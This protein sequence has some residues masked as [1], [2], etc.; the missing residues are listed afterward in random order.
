MTRLKTFQI[1]ILAILEVVDHTRILKKTTRGTWRRNTLTTQQTFITNIHLQ[2][3]T[4]TGHLRQDLHI[5]N[6]KL[7]QNNTARI[8]VGQGKG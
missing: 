1:K 6:I 5:I 2:Q 7:I 3:S 8:A 4:L